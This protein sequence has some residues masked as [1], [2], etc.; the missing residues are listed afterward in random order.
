MPSAVKNILQHH[1]EGDCTTWGWDRF[2]KVRA[3]AD[4]CNGHAIQCC[5]SDTHGTIAGRELQQRRQKMPERRWALPPTYPCLCFTPKW[6]DFG[7]R[8]HDAAAWGEWRRQGCGKAAQRVCSRGVMPS[9][10]PRCHP[11]PWWLWVGISW[12]VALTLAN[13]FSKHCKTLSTTLLSRI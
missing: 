6:R 10:F 5:A 7:Y 2:W 13:F 9:P 1:E 12:G 8:G 3:E 11:G 4:A